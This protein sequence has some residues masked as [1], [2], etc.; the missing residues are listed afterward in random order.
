MAAKL[1]FQL[2]GEASSAVSAFK[3]TTD[4]SKTASGAATDTGKTLAGIAGAVATGYAVKK[5]VDFGKATV[6]AAGEAAH[7]NKLVT[8][9]FKNAGDATGQYSKHAIEL[10]DSLGRQIGVSPQV[11]KGAEGILATFH[12]VSG[13]AG[14]QAGIF[15]RTTKAAADLA[16][17][18]FGTMEGNAKQLGIAL[19]NPEKGL[20][21]LTKSGV[22]FTEAQKEQIKHMQQSGD[23]LGAQKMILAEVERQVGGTAAATAGAGAKMSVSYE[24]MKVAI[25]TSLLPAVGALKN[26][27][28][29]LFDL[30]GSN[31]TWL[32]PLIAAGAAFAVVLFTV[33]KAVQMTQIA[34][35]GFKLAI[36]GTKLAWMLL[37]STFLASP[38]GIIIVAVIALVAILVILYLKVD[39]VRAGI[40]AA[41][42]GIVSAALW[43]WG[44]IVSVFNAIVGFIQGWGGLVLALILGPWVLVFALVM[45]AI[46]GGWSGVVAQLNAWLG[47]ITGVFSRVVGIISGPFVSA[48]NA[49][50]SGFLGPLFAAFSGVAGAIANAIAGV[51][52]AI[53]GPFNKALGFINQNIIGPLKSAWNGVANVINSVSISTPEV[54]VLGHTIIPAFHW[55]PPWRV[56]TLAVGGLMTRSGLVYA[57]AGEVISPAPASATRG[58]RMDQ[59]V[60]IETANFGERV[61]VDSFGKR[62]AWQLRTSGV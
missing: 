9:E 33:A 20:A 60:K 10:A 30:V 21:K 51:Y 38:I 17:A 62:L 56:P 35:Q 37:N 55:E 52:D 43:L 59:L 46:N 58:S 22:N 45:A 2:V 11:I 24:E 36:E 25:G 26:M 7:A 15:D 3:S 48:W 12:S 42:S 27:F 41:F 44:A 34:I 23:L 61:D 5:V 32:V 4:A 1:I 19:E 50:Y 49:V 6:D 18:G 28:A 40:D 29:G 14:V 54:S 47:V 31:A 8:Q 13:A 57:H 16:A 53:I 39:W